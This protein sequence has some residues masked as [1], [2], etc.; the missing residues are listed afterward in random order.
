MKTVKLTLQQSLLIHSLRNGW[1][2]KLRGKSFRLFDDYAAMTDN[3]IPAYVVRSVIRKGL[4]VH[5]RTGVFEFRSELTELGRTCE[6]EVK[7]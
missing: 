4:V 5:I 6:I 3:P 1:R 2:L 7:K